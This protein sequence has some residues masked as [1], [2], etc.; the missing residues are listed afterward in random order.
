MVTRSV[1]RPAV[2]VGD[3]VKV[4]SGRMGTVTAI[5]G[6]DTALAGRVLVSFSKRRHLAVWTPAAFV[7]IVAR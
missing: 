3:T 1:M 5:G 6:A 2:R 7:L 4:R